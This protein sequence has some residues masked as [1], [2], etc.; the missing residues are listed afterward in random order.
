MAA[1]ARGRRKTTKYGNAEKF[2]FFSLSLH[3]FLLLDGD[4]PLPPPFSPLSAVGGVAC[5]IHLFSSV[6]YTYPP[7]GSVG[8]GTVPRVVLYP[9]REPKGCVFCTEL[10]KWILHA[11]S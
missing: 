1:F 10:R 8:T 4:L 9:S 7:I 3:P 5:S 6:Q 11:T 2:L